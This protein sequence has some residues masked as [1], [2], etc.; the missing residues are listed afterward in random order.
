M[1]CAR[2]D[3]LGLGT[4]WYGMLMDGTGTRG[5]NGR[6]GTDRPAGHACPVNVYEIQACQCMKMIGVY[7][8]LDSI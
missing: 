2:E 3:C 4:A 1:S 7:T 6:M 5:E 8:V